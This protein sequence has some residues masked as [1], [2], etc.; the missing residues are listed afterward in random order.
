VHGVLWIDSGRVTVHSGI[1]HSTVLTSAQSPSRQ[2]PNL[3]PP[4]ILYRNPRTAV[5]L[6]VVRAVFMIK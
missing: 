4:C 3:T 2:A 1:S 6:H 5:H